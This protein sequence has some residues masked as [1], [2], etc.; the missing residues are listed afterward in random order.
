[1][2]DFNLLAAHFSDSLQAYGSS[3]SAAEWAALHAVVPEPGTLGLLA[4]GAL[5]LL[6]RRRGAARLS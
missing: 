2:L 4:A 5:G 1:V 3:P 6:R